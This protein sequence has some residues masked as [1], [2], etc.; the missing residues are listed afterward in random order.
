MAGSVKRCW[1]VQLHHA[2]LP[3]WPFSWLQLSLLMLMILHESS[4]IRVRSV[5]LWYV[6]NTK[7]CNIDTC[8]SI[9][10]GFCTELFFCPNSFEMRMV[11]NF[12]L[13]TNSFFIDLPEVDPTHAM[14]FMSKHLNVPKI[15]DGIRSLSCWRQPLGF[16]GMIF[17]GSINGGHVD[18]RKA[19]GVQVLFV[20]VV[21]PRVSPADVASESKHIFFL[22]HACS[23]EIFYDILIFYISGSPQLLLIIWMNIVQPPRWWLTTSSNWNLGI[24]DKSTW[25]K[26]SWEQNP[27]GKKEKSSKQ[28]SKGTFFFFQI[29]FSGRIFLRKTTRSHVYRIHETGIFTYIYH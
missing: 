9:F 20:V 22:Q 3:C 24:T 12:W 5:F 1:R 21:F 28:K 19:Q 11:T 10:A 17:N 18:G 29:S 13:Y 8:E 16:L 6:P 4:M 14:T 25:T 15:L 2:V 27:G 26:R 7:R 23:K